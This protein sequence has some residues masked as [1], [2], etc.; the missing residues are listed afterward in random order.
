[1]ATT[2]THIAVSP[3]EVWSVLADP[4][5]YPTWVVGTVKVRAADPAWPTPGSKLHHAV[6]AWPL[7]LHDDSEVLECEPGRRLVMQARGWPAGEARVELVLHAEGDST[8]RVGMVEEPTHGP[9]AW[10]HNRL[11]DRVLIRRMDECLDRL[12]RL[13]EGRH[14]ARAG[15]EDVSPTRS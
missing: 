14:A 13:A 3:D 6:G 4:W 7:L 2:S 12:R 11:L 9:G 5:S 8:T 15:V 1:M 10:V